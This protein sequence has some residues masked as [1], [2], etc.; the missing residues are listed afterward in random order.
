MGILGERTTPPQVD[1]DRRDIV[2]SSTVSLI[3]QWQNKN[4]GGGTTIMAIFLAA[5]FPIPHQDS[6]PF[7]SCSVL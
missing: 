7:K 3:L 2:F 5:H 4:W 6:I 1:S